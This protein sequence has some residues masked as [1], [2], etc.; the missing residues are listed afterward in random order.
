MPV[1]Y[2][3]L[4]GDRRFKQID[5]GHTALPTC[6]AEYLKPGLKCEEPGEFDAPTPH[7]PWADFCRQHA[8]E[9]STK[10]SSIGFHRIR[11]EN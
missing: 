11:R 9:F 2:T 5:W 1:N 6:K 10:N 7:G 3:L 4:E 8:E